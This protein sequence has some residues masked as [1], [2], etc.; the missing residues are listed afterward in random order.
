MQVHVDSGFII[1]GVCTLLVG[2][3]LFGSLYFYYIHQSLLIKLKNSA[4]SAIAAKASLNSIDSKIIYIS[5][6][7]MVCYFFVP[8][9]MTAI[10]ITN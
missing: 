8:F 4:N 10:V 5:T 2:F 3:F 6:T 9:L 1:F 7:V